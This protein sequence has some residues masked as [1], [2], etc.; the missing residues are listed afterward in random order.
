MIGTTDPKDEFDKKAFKHAIG[1]VESSG[2]KF[3]KS[4]TSSAAGK[5]HF[6]WNLIK[7]NKSLKGLSKREFIADPDLQERVMDQALSGELD[8]YPNYIKYAKSLKGRFNSDLDVTKI[9]ALTHFL[10][11]GNVKKYLSDPENFKVSG[12]NLNPSDYL[13]KFDRHFNEFKPDPIIDTGKDSSKGLNEIKNKEFSK[14][15]QQID[16]T[17]VGLG[18]VSRNQT[19]SLNDQPPQNGLKFNEFRLGGSVGEVDEGLTRFESGGSHEENP[20]GGIPQGVGA[21][22]GVNLV[23]EGETKWND[24]IFSNS[25]TI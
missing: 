9:A 5:Y 19:I 15:N 18:N 8:G 4:N 22:G 20:I 7:D 23:E 2:G 14:T 1:M 11:S 25:I 21:N 6:L 24:Y 16:N 12:E 3:L 13:S 10:G 17:R